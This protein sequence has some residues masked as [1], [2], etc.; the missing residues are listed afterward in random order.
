VGPEGL[1]DE[2]LTAAARRWLEIV[3]WTGSVLWE[4]QRNLRHLIDMSIEGTRDQS[5]STCGST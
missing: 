5:E 3:G 2:A 1:P 4:E